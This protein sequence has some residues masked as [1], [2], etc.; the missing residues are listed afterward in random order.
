MDIRIVGRNEGNKE[1]KQGIN[2]DKKET[3]ER[4]KIEKKKD[5]KRQNK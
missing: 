3:E 5:R 4:R 1:R 2:Y